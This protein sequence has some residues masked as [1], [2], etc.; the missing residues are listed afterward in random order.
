MRNLIIL[1]LIG[2]IIYIVSGIYLNKEPEKPLIER[3][4]I[5]LGLQSG[6]KTNKP[7]HY[8]FINAPIHWY[9]RLLSYEKLSGE[10]Y[11]L[12]FY[13]NK[14]ADKKVDTILIT[15]L[16]NMKEFYRQNRG[17]ILWFQGTISRID[18]DIPGNEVVYVKGNLIDQ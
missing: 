16:T 11:M 9:G 2:F 7:P 4:Q 5:M 8:Q 15:N 10:T 6:E 17:K 14:E 1:C 12:K 18:P 13:V 3:E